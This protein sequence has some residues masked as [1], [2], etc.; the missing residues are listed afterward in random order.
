[1]NKRG[2]RVLSS[3][4]ICEIL[5]AFQRQCI[6]CLFSRDIDVFS[7]NAEY[8]S[9]SK[10]IN[11]LKVICKMNLNKIVVAYLNINLIPNK[12]EALIHNASWEVDLLIISEAKIDDSFQKSQFSIKRV[13]PVILFV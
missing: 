10:D 1:M 12:F 9:K 7:K 8:K 6:L 2:A 13:S 3:N 11:H 5:N 4:F